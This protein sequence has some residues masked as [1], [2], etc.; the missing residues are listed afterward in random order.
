MCEIELIEGAQQGSTN[1]FT[2]LVVLYQKRL[3]G[4]LLA[5]SQNRQEVEDIVQETFLNAFRHIKS[6]DSRWQFST[7]IYTIAR[8]IASKKSSVT[9]DTAFDSE[10]QLA[11][12]L[13]IYEP[14]KNIWVII[15]QYM[16]D[17]D[18]DTLWFYFSQ[19]LRIRDIAHIL[20]KS[21]SW[22]K[23]SLYRSK[24]KLARLKVVKQLFL[25]LSQE[26]VL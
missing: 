11:I 3:F 24:K 4:Y 16:K 12:E 8:R 7:W 15:R 10:Q 25:Q 23:V 5:H 19:N 2:Q 9:L 14:L 21:E 22:V 13:K 18:F 26:Q 17:D 1:C 6:Y 20:Q